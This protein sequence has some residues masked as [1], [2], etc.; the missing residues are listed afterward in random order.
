MSATSSLR[1][2]ARCA[3][4]TVDVSSFC[5]G[6]SL[7]SGVLVI[8]IFCLVNA[9]LAFAGEAALY[10]G[11]ASALADQAGGAYLAP[12]TKIND[13]KV[14]AGLV[15]VGLYLLISSIAA[16][17]AAVRRN[18]IAALITFAI[19]AVDLALAIAVIVITFLVN[20][21]WASLLAQV[22][23]CVP[24]AYPFPPVRATALS[25]SLPANTPPLFS[26]PPVSSSM[27]TSSSSRAPST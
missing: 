13:V 20:G 19:Q 1:A 12:G 22:P 18:V 7:A 15:F 11:L 27:R 6:C 21:S 23:P 3:S 14:Q 24:R 25:F 26:P 17:I 2:P 8:A 5:C 4:F 9:S 10:S 16:F